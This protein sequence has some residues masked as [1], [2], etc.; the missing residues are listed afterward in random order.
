MP[1]SEA[2]GSV[3][4]K[5]KEGFIGLGESEG[6]VGARF[7]IKLV[8]ITNKLLLLCLGQVV[9]GQHL[10]AQR[11]EGVSLQSRTGMALTDAGDGLQ[12]LVSH[13]FGAEKTMQYVGRCA[14]AIDLWGV[15]EED[16]N[17]VKQSAG[18][19][20]ALVQPQFGMGVGA[21]ESEVSNLPTVVEQ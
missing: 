2:L 20:K 9:V 15:A 6:G 3:I 16:T 17:V 14:C 13:Q 21:T 4:A 19:D 7:G 1:M 12:P 8:G 5:L 11:Q 18:K 10:Q